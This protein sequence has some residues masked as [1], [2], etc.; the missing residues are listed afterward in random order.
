[1]SRTI[2][3]RVVG[4]KFN[5]EQFQSRVKATLGSIE[6]LKKGLKLEGAAKGLQAVQAVSDKFSLAGIANSVQSIAERFG[7]LGVIGI[8]ALANITSRAVDMGLQL[9]KSLTI[10][11]IAEGFSDYNAKLTSVQTIM[12]ATGKSIEVVGGYFSELDTYADK[13]IYNLGDMTGAFAKFT[14]AGVDMDKSVPAIKGIANM[15]AL[16]GQDANAASIAMYNLSQSIAGGFLTTTDYKS[17][18]LANVATKEWKDQMIQGA[19][20]AGTLKKG[21]DGMYTIPG[22]KGA[23]TDASLFAEAL[24]EGWASAEVLTTVL[25]DYG[26]TTTAIGAKAQAAAQ[27]VKSF[28]MMMDTLKAGVGT[29]W[30]DTFEILVGNLT[31]AKALFTPLTN[32]ISGFLEQMASARNTPL[33]EWKDMGGR[34]A[35]I[36]AVKNAFAALMAIIKPIKEAFVQIF[37]PTTGAQLANITKAIEAFTK[38]LMPTAKDTENLKTIF[39]GLF[40]TVDMV[41]QVFK[42]L[43]GILGKVLMAVGSLIGP[44]LG[45]LAAILGPRVE[46]D[47]FLKSGNRMADVFDWIGDKLVIPIALLKQF[48]DWLVELIDTMKNVDFNDIGA[49]FPGLEKAMKPIQRAGE[50]LASVWEFLGRAFGRLGD[51]LAPVGGMIA[52]TVDNIG[53]GIED[54]MNGVDF[55]KVLDGIN[56]GLLAGIT[57]MLSKLLKGGLKV[58]FG[59]GILE[60]I[61]SAFGGVTDTLSTMQSKLKAEALQKIAVAIGILVASVVVLSLIDSKKLDSALLAMTAMFVQLGVSMAAMDKFVI[62]KNIAKMPLL[63]AA[64]IVLGVAVLVLAGS[65]KKLSE[66]DWNEL[67]RGVSG[68]AAIMIILV[69][70]TSKMEK[71]APGMIATAVGLTA[72]GVALKILASSVK[73]FADLDW[74]ELGRGVA[75]LASVMFL[76]S[77]FAKGLTNPVGIVGTAV[78]LVI[79]GGALKVMANALKDLG[80]LDVETLAKG[81]VSMGVGLKILTSSMNLMSPKAAKGMIVNAAALVIVS[82]ALMLLVPSLIKMGEMSWEEIAKAGTALAGSLAII[83]GAMQLMPSAIPGAL[84]LVVV[85]AGLL[86]LSQAFRQMAKMS[87]DD[88]GRVATILTGSLL[89]IAGGMYVMSGALPGAAALVVV[90]AALAI[91]APV[92]ILLGTMSW[93]AI[94]KGLTVLAGALVAIGIGGV[95]LVLAVPGLMGLAAAIALI[96]YGA[97]LAG[98]GML[99]FGIGFAAVAGA[100]AISSEVLKAALQTIID[101]IPSFMESIGQ[102]I[103]R[104]AAVISESGPTLVDALVTVIMSI[105]AAVVET[106]PAMTDGFVVVMTGLLT[107]INQTSPQIIDTL[108]RLVVRLVEETV[109]NVPKF[110]DAGL[111]LLVGILNGIASNMPALT[112]AG[113]NVVVTFIN[114]VSNNIPR[115]VQA[116]VNLV[117]NFVN[118][119]ANGIRDNQGRMDAAGRNLASAIADGMTGGLASKVGAVVAGARRLVEGIPGAIKKIL[120]IASPSKVTT[121]LGEFTGMG[122]VNGMLNMIG[123]VYNAA[124]SVGS[125]VISGLKSSMSKVS[126]TIATDVDIQ[127]TVRPVLDLTDFKKTAGTMGDMLP[128]PTLSLDSS[129]SAA[130][131]ASSSYRDAQAAKQE[132]ADSKMTAPTVTKEISL[133][134]VNQSPKA[135]DDIEIYRQTHNLISQAKTILEEDA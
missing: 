16:A 77:K 9:V 96:G 62:G 6:D 110:V 33:I 107:A 108:S 76:L 48:V 109:K 7:A 105:V 41:W 5:N 126:D 122:V 127:P 68:V 53:H 123:S 125:S 80:K 121:A 66:L 35:A 38:R 39:L 29:G 99:A 51:M 119:L 3:E 124:T 40:A 26:D 52:D 59:G 56:V 113:T 78:S 46:M 27:D 4:M 13:T 47:N 102:G 89:L 34:T 23:Y 24:S 79:L 21:T 115:V 57:L 18:N 19:I 30:T 60:T 133:T 43:A 81:L 73:D 45:L 103:I 44:F 61:K 20:A 10:A 1:M 88:I 129:Y 111:R 70:A 106:A 132:V 58:D 22:A 63:A 17:L 14:N 54:L 117:V 118:A 93:E 84:S 42:G 85:S 91:L 69:G 86:V 50:V 28:S 94:G 8:T 97:A 92:L 128:T 112:N 134:Q 49:S 130:S 37:P 95:G 36:E 101:M 104:F 64:M 74:E 31:E 67:A 75:G 90:S 116:A 71:A 120:G 131:A 114:G 87:W 65:V 98:A 135:L 11:P 55:D 12:N 25:G 82:A 72:M 2:D 15:V 32:T 83:A 100:A